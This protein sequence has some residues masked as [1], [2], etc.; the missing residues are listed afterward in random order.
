DTT[1]A[2]FDLELAV[3]ESIGEDGIQQ[4][5]SAEFTF[6]ADLF[7]VSTVEGFARRLVR[8]LETVVSIP[9]IVVGDI[10]ILDAA[11]R[12][13]LA[14]VHGGQSVSGTL[15]EILT[16][17]AAVDPSADAIRF[18]GQSISYR[19]LDERSSQLARVLIA[20]GVGPEDRVA[21]AIPRSA[22]SVLA[23]WAVVKTGA[24]FVPVDPTYPVDRIAH[25]ISDS[26][27]VLGLA[28]S[29]VEAG[30]PS[31]L[32]WVVLDDKK[33]AAACAAE[34]CAPVSDSDRRSAIDERQPAYVIYTSGS[35][36]KPKGVVVGHRGL[37][38]MYHNHRLA[39]RPVAMIDSATAAVPVTPKPCPRNSGLTHTP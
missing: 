21:I 12:G 32:T 31:A 34:S 8:I 19:E 14:D 15:V 17:A 3:T 20:K 27:A 7:D 1:T 9:S 5:L 18:D 38:T 28:L 10:D 26:G 24:A 22:D 16:A 35:T 39:M 6:A 25:M 30:L 13:V 33:T 23:L 11:E 36:G 37:T 2:K 29:D 4:G